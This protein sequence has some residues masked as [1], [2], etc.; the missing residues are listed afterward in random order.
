M[1]KKQRTRKPTVKDIAREAQVSPTTV[2]L[3]LRDPKTKRVSAA[4]R[5]QV[6]KIAEKLKYRPN[7]VA[8][9]LVGNESRTIG[10]VLTTL[11]IPFYAEIAQDIIAS[12]K[13]NSYSVII[14]TT[15][16]FLS[17]TKARID[18]ER[19]AIY[20]LL[21]RGVDGRSF[22]SSPLWNLDYAQPRHLQVVRSGTSGHHGNHSLNRSEH[23]PNP[24]P[25][26]KYLM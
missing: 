20:D 13:R 19:Q 22:P 5:T 1:K 6:I 12:A 4:K 14:S 8:R 24:P 2:S 16:E 11:T 9:N 18:E 3:V 25:I 7:F 15:R 10:L 21:D 17:T 26:S 23:S